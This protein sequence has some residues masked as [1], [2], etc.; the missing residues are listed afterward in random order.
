[1]PFETSQQSP[2]ATAFLR[3]AP[4]ASPA[5][6]ELTARPRPWEVV[7]AVLTGRGGVGYMRLHFLS[8]LRPWKP[9]GRSRPR[10]NSG[11]VLLSRFCDKRT[12]CVKAC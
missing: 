9:I 1:M 7:R 4:M 6:A 12:R 8:D 10:L 5:R 2:T 11:A 3:R